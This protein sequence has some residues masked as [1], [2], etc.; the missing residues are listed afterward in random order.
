MAEV[1]LMERE[2]MHH[3]AFQRGETA[4]QGLNQQRGTENRKENWGIS[5]SLFESRKS[6]APG[7]EMTL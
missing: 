5:F 7:R 3:R 6:L 1:T 4:S 2:S